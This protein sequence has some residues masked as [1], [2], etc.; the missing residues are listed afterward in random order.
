MGRIGRFNGG[1]DPSYSPRL[2]SATEASLLH[3]VLC[4]VN[5]PLIATNLSVLSTMTIHLTSDIHIMGRTDTAN[6]RR[7]PTGLVSTPSLP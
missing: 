1:H 2:I 5:C 6:R 3:T 7:P 4:Q